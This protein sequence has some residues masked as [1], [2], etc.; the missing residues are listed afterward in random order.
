MKKL[1][2]SITV[3][4]KGLPVKNTL[5]YLLSLDKQGRT[6]LSKDDPQG[7]GHRQRDGGHR[8]LAFRKPMLTNLETKDKE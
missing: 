3:S 4:W 8:P 6:S 7:E 2:R 1:D 5:T